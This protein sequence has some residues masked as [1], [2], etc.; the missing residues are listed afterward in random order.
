MVTSFVALAGLKAACRSPE[1]LAEVHPS[2]KN[3]FCFEITVKPRANLAVGAFESAVMVV[4]QLDGGK[5]LPAKLIPINGRIIEDLQVTPPA[6][7]FGARQVGGLAEETVMLHSESGRRFH[8]IGVSAEGSG[9]VVE[10]M[11]ATL[12]DTPTFKIRQ[13]ITETGAQAT[14]VIFRV[15]TTDGKDVQVLL[16]VNYLGLAKS[17]P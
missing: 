1:F 10:S 9:L 6:A 2:S 16:P 5:E 4:P 11:P 13:R 3:P 15:R 17:P 8:V 14:R 7:M 12:T